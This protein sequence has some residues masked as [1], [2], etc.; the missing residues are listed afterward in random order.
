MNNKIKLLTLSDH[1][2]SPSGVGTQTR[3]I[4]ESLLETGMFQVHS[5]GGAMKH[6]SYNVTK[7]DKWGDDWLIHPVDGY[8]TPEM[9]RSFFN[10]LENLLLK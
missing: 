8:G 6:E 10:S 9:I 7:T 5:F 3:Y 4:I 2:L 1:P